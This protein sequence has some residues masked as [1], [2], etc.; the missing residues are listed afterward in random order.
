MDAGGMGWFTDL[1]QRVDAGWQRAGRN[2][3][4]FPEIATQALGELPPPPSLGAVPVLRHAIAD[5]L[6]AEQDAGTFGQPSLVL[7]RARDFYISALY[8]LD[9]T[10]S[11][12]QHAF[13]G[14]FRVLE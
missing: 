10:T 3:H 1:G 4:A 8:W 9:G 13:S 5:G 2:E 6:T 14:A 12:H 11:I 7:H